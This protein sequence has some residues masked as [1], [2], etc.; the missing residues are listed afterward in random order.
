MRSKQIRFILIAAIILIAAAGCLANTESNLILNKPPVRF[1]IIGDR[2]GSNTPDIYEEI[3]AEIER[4]KPDFV[5]TV[6][7]AIEGYTDDTVTL[8]RQWD[9]YLSIVKPFTMPIYF[10]PGNHDITTDAALGPFRQK[11]GEAYYSFNVRNY[12]IIVLDVTRWDSGEKLPKTELDW[13]TQD[14]ASHHNATQTL[15][16][17]HKPFWY[18]TVTLG[19]SDTLHSLFVAFGVDAVFNGHLHTYFSEKLD[20]IQYTAVGSSGGI[21]D[22]V[23]SDLE[24]HFTWVT[25]DDSGITIAPI[26]KGSV[27]PWDIV[28]AAEEHLIDKI[29]RQSM[30]FVEAA[31]VSEDLKVPTAT[32]K[33]ELNN[34]AGQVLNDTI[35]WQIPEGWAVKPSILP[36]SVPAKEKRQVDFQVSCMSN[37]Y[38]LPTASL[39]FPYGEGKLIPLSE[40]LRISRIAAAQQA[41]VAPKIDGILN[42]R[43]WGNPST[44][45]FNPD[46][47]AAAVESTWFYFAYD[48]N[49]LYVAARCR[50]S[51]MDSIRAAVTARDGA[52]TGEDCVGFFIQPDLQI[53]TAYQIYFNPL[54]TVF[55]QKIYFGSLGYFTGSKSWNGSYSV[56]AT[57][58]KGYWNVE[59]R[60]PLKQLKA[61]G[62]SGQDW[63]INFLRK[64]KRLDAAAD[65]QAPIDYNPKTFG[66]LKLK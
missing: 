15:V 40:S 63:G 26:K 5:M 41:V 19:K 57:R 45:L 2:T 37:L 42:D 35:H 61:I 27:K 4:L 48:K 7:D 25:I 28:T 9:E 16:F 20:G 34:L 38:P 54:G 21:A 22:A 12:H 53:D 32:I 59:A 52:V 24:Y 66:K 65:W 56:K 36:V 50:E 60:I 30:S 47:G 17:F 10:T 64:Q 49:N 6:G 23:A 62:K 14:L 58:D 1:A 33:L 13:L 29:I 31:P 39:R 11:I 46:G 3:I 55:D 51:K 18:D 44:R 8:D 43:C